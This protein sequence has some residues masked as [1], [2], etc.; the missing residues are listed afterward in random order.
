MTLEVSWKSGDTDITVATPRLTFTTDDWDTP[1]TIRIRAEDDADRD[2]GSAVIGH[3]TRGGGYTGVAIADVTATE[4]DEDVGLVLSKGTLRIAEG[5][6]GTYTVA[7]AAEPGASVTVAV[8]KQ[9]GGDDDLEVAPSSLVFTT[10]NWNTGQTVTVGADA[11]TDVVEGMARILHRAGDDISASVAVFEIDDDAAVDLA[12]EAEPLPVEEG[13]SAEYTI[14]LEAQPSGAVTIGLRARGDPDLGVSPAALTFTTGTWGDAQTVT[15]SAAEDRDVV[16]GQALVSHVVAGGDYDRVAIPGVPVIEVENDMLGVTLSES[17]IGVPEGGSAAY[18]VVLEAQPSGAVTI[19]LTASGDGDLRASPAALTF[20]TGNW[21]AAQTVTVVAAPDAD[22]AHGEA[23]IAHAIAG[24]GYDGVAVAAVTLTEEDDDGTLLLSA[25]RVVVPEDGEEEWTVRLAGRPAE[26]VT[27]SLS[28]EGDADLT[29]S[30]ETLTFTTASWNTP[31]TV[32]AAA[33]DDPDATNGETL[34]TLQAA[35]GAFS[36]VSAVVTAVEEDDDAE[37]VLSSTAVTIPE[38]ESRNWTVALGAAPGGPVTVAIRVVGSDSA[39][40][41]VSPDAL[42]FTTANWQRQQTAT[43]AVAEDGDVR[44]NTAEVRHLANGGGYVVVT[45]SVTVTQTDNDS[46]IVLQHRPR[47]SV[48]YVPLPTRLLVPEG[49]AGDQPSVSGERVLVSLAEPPD[50]GTTEVT[51]NVRRVGDT[52]LRSTDLQDPLST[53]TL[54]KGGGWDQEIIIHAQNDDDVLW[55][56]ATFEF[57]MAGG[58]VNSLVAV[59]Q[60]DDT[61]ITVVAPNPLEITEGGS[62]TYTVALGAAPAEEVEVAVRW[63]EDKAVTA[64]PA[65]LTFTTSNW[66]TAQTVTVSATPDADG[67]D[68]SVTLKHRATGSDYEFAPCRRAAHRQQKASTRC[69][70]KATGGDYAFAPGANVKVDVT[71]SDMVGVTIK[72]DELVASPP[73][74]LVVEEGGSNAYT[75]QLATRPGG[76]G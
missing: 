5:D 60:D 37:L 51:V 53:V 40:F 3:A 45:G 63:N 70:E 47:D 21:S 11:D 31:Q 69:W 14:R 23:T 48:T 58:A 41:A 54:G 50:D 9:A 26:P 13:G 44:D 67:D 74:T 61:K 15:V 68:F 73:Q 46:N 1:Q 7:L 2:N 30:P 20:T 19:D 29:V 72:P 27:V 64:N 75:L 8:T 16:V 49:T 66:R 56:E 28:T 17:A 22:A 33:A 62:G 43:V 6:T 10:S 38:G 59:E 39:S 35:G 25:T 55:G 32:T 71:D 65:V 42:T 34:V 24:G 4:E 18:T 12:V 76:A 52:D 36:G 57:S